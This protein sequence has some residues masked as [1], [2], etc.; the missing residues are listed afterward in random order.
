MQIPPVQANWLLSEAD[1]DFLSS[2]VPSWY[3]QHQSFSKFLK[4]VCT[5]A[6][7]K[8][9]NNTRSHLSRGSNNQWTHSKGITYQTSKSISDVSQQCKRI[10]MHWC[11][12][13]L[14]LHCFFFVLEL[15]VTFSC[16]INYR[17]YLPAI[18]L[19]THAHIFW[20]HSGTWRYFFTGMAQIVDRRL[21]EL[22]T[23]RDTDAGTWAG[24]SPNKLV[25]C[26]T[27]MNTY[28]QALLTKT[29]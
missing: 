2:L 20:G 1:Y 15:N 3:I 29:W 13:K 8:T 26:Q 11:T 24:R 22:L 5:G 17:A 10:M 16:D 9:D 27:K 6:F 18:N 25:N 4:H 14:L 23:S 12:K 28:T 21:C 7:S 19:A